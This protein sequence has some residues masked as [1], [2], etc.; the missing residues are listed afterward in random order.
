MVRVKICGVTRGEDALC[1]VEAGASAVGF[2]FVP[3]S[4]RQ[5]TPAAARAMIRT[6]PPFVTS[7]GV[8]VDATRGEINRLIEET[9]IGCLQ[10]HGDET[11]DDVTGYPVPVYKAFRVGPGFDPRILGKYPVQAC[12]LDSLIEG[13]RGG[14][15][16]TFKWDIA[17]QAK[18]YARIIL[19]GG[20]TPANVGEAIRQ[21]RPYA[22]DVSSGV[23]SSPGVKDRNT[24]KRLMEAVQMADH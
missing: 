11:P 14:T 3:G 12:L 1:A 15:G 19:S 23:E 21:V 18:T 2:I 24:I 13:V 17:L 9:G 10:L 16:R 20:I 22:V 5:V 7:V 6:I 4:P 8:V